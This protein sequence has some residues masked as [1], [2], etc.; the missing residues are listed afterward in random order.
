MCY[1]FLHVL[2]LAP[3]LETWSLAAWEGH[4]GG[5]LLRVFRRNGSFTKVFHQ[6][7]VFFIPFGVPVSWGSASFGS[8][9]GGGRVLSGC[10]LVS[11]LLFSL[12]RLTL[13]QHLR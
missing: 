7:K 9:D 1:I 11:I 6:S 13:Q 5:T 12:P 10:I 3:Q 4:D 2:V 8:N